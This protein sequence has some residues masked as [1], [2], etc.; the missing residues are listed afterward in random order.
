VCV[1][2]FPQ[3][4]T[5]GNAPPPPP[6]PLSEQPLP[7]DQ[8]TPVVLEL[9]DEARPRLRSVRVKRIAHGARVRFRLSEPGSVTVR[10]KRGGQTVK[11]RSLRV[12][13]AGTRTLS[14][15]GLRAGSYRIEVLARDLA[16]NR[17]RVAHARLTVRG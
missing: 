1:L 7:N 3:W 12:R 11:A 10:A 17:S 15:R 8:T 13:R 2:A 9:T 6:P 4:V 16:G 5:V 14:L